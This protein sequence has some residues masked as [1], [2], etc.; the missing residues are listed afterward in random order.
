M[1]CVGNGVGCIMGESE[2]GAVVG[3][4]AVVADERP[5]VGRNHAAA[6]PAGDPVLVPRVVTEGEGR[7]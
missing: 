2:A 3:G 4:G 7:C 1:A 5:E 6:D